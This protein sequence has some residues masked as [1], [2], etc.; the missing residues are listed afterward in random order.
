MTITEKA[1]SALDAYEAQKAARKKLAKEIKQLKE[2]DDALADAA[3]KKK[4]AAADYKS[5]LFQ[6]EGRNERALTKLEEA[7]ATEK[8]L[9]THFDDI[10]EEMRDQAVIASQDLT[11]A[12]VQMDLFVNGKKATVT[13]ATKITIEKDGPKNA[14]QEPAD[15]AE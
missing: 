15:D 4:D 1:Q 11:K 5:E 8:E 3:K 10:Y 12:P 6:F 13:L 2:D 14:A 9:R 7:V